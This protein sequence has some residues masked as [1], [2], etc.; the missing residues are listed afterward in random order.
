MSQYAGRS[1]VELACKHGQIPAYK[2]AYAQLCEDLSSHY[3]IEKYATHEAG[4]YIFS[5]RIGFTEFT[6][7]GPTMEFYPDDEE[8]P[9]KYYHASVRSPQIN[10]I[11]LVTENE[12]EHIARLGV[13]G[14]VFNEIR[15]LTP[16]VQM[17]SSDDYRN[18][19]KFCRK[20]YDEDGVPFNPPFYWRMARPHVQA[21]LLDPRNEQEI[22]DAVIKMKA[23][24]FYL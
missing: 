17:E 24:C 11:P 3:N 18:F 6:F 22:Q 4:H 10:S 21:Y 23:E 7:D 15:Q 13:A 8:L 19:V 14:H 2:N 5:K 20:A 9:Y 12:L 1:I 16:A